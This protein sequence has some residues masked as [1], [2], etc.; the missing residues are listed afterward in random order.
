ME[1][2]AFALDD[3]VRIDAPLTP[4]AFTYPK[5]HTATSIP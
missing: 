5:L 3:D 4:K 2:S 1:S